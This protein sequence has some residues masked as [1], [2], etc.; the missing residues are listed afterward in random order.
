[1]IMEITRNPTEQRAKVID[2][3]LEAYSTRQRK[4]H[5]SYVANKVTGNVSIQTKAKE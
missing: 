3:S 4:E 2:L 1:M 5:V